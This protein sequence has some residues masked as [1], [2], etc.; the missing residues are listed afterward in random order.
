[1][2]KDKHKKIKITCECKTTFDFTNI[3]YGD[4][5]CGM[6][7]FLNCPTCKQVV[8]PSGHRPIDMKEETVEV[9][10]KDPGWS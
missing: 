6:M 8:L 7:G 3:Q 10:G 1:M 4:F 9:D 5:D 2:M